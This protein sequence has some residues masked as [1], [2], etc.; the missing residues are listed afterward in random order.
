MNET[1]IYYLANVPQD[2]RRRV[3]DLC[4]KRLWHE[5]LDL[6]RTHGFGYY[7]QDDLINFYHWAPATLPHQA[8]DPTPD[9]FPQAP[10]DYPQPSPEHIDDIQ[11]R[12]ADVRPD[13]LERVHDA[14]K[15]GTIEQAGSLLWHAGAGFS[16]AELYEYR[17]TLFPPNSLVDAY[18]PGPPILRPSDRSADEVGR[19]VLAE[20][21]TASPP[22]SS[23]SSPSNCVASDG[24]LTTDNGHLT[25]GHSL[26]VANPDLPPTASATPELQNVKPEPAPEAPPAALS[27]IPA[28]PAPEQAVARK[29]RGKIPALPKEIRDE[30]NAR[31]E[32]N[33]SYKTIIRWL[34]RKGHP[35]FN[36]QNLHLWKKGGYQDWRRENERIQTQIMHREWLTEQVAQTKPGELFIL[37]DQ[38][39][40]TQLLDSLFGLDTGLM[41]QGLAASPRHFI[42]L[43][44]A[45]NRFKRD[46]MNTEPFRAF[47]QRERERTRAGKRGLSHEAMRIIDEAFGLRPRQPDPDPA[48]PSN[49]V[50][51]SQT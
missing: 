10:R 15:Q 29:R 49:I 47:L 1:P 23:S 26:P 21:H 4:F 7:N 11:K 43:F 9:P 2:L 16:S 13:V 37:I 14:L 17:K 45:Y 12:L 8:A 39:F 42:S 28:V 41:K 35:G 34:T 31:L 20:P 25:A 22:I 46:A 6:L 27:A 36:Q 18:T 33:D 40:V 30:L 19:G 48:Q 50:K 38:L 5:G 32:A 24:P 51:D 44:S 3:L